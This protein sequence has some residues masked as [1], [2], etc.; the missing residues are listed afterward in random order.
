MGRV[1]VDAVFDLGGFTGF[2]CENM[3]GIGSDFFLK[4]RMI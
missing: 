3:T 4:D 2:G 1:Q